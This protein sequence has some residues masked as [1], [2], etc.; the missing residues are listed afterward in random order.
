MYGRTIY[1][2]ELL[3]YLIFLAFFT[4][5]SIYTSE[6]YVKNYI[7]LGSESEAKLTICNATG[8]NDN[9]KSGVSVFLEIGIF[10]ISFI[11]LLIELFQLLRVSNSEES[12]KN[13]LIL[14]KVFF[15]V[16]GN[17]FN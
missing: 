9:T 4:T 7:E 5:F 1:Y 3:L 16:A 8:I 12:N 14:N 15:R 17:T 2:F 10:G 6:P 13:W 11:S